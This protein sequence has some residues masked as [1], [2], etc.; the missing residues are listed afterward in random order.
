MRIDGER[1]GQPGHRRQSDRLR[2]P[3]AHPWRGRWKPW[4]EGIIM[5]KAQTLVDN[6]SDN[7]CN[8]GLWYPY[9][10]AETEV[11]GRLEI[12]PASG[13]ADTYGGYTSVAV[14]VAAAG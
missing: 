5:A 13:V 11:N 9:G 1:D 6:F 7:A 10:G 4:Q 8:T 2:S 12:R 14:R 3:A